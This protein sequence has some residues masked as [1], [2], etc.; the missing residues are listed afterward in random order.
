M[1][2]LKS[3]VG[4]MSENLCEKIVEAACEE[5]YRKASR[6]ISELSG[7]TISH[8][9]V[10]KVT[11]VMGKRVEIEEKAA[12]ARAKRSEG[13]GEVERKVLFEEND[14]IYLSLQGESR[15]KRGSHAEMKVGLIGVSCI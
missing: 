4:H 13:T 15:K 6:T 14:G 1:L 12:A 10:W 2:E 5:P 11:Q 9:G 7:Q 3:G 8:Q